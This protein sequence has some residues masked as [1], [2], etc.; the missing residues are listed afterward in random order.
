[1]IWLVN[2]DIHKLNT[3]FLNTYRFRHADD[4]LLM[5]Q[6]EVK[7]YWKYKI[8]L[9]NEITSTERQELKQ[10][11][12]HKF[13]FSYDFFLFERAKKLAVFFGSIEIFKTTTQYRA[14]EWWK[15]RVNLVME[16]SLADQIRSN[17][18]E[19]CTKYQYTHEI[20]WCV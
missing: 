15:I 14:S 18:M 5:Q 20:T 8:T 11:N 17:A 2:N 4:D 13:F 6:M 9:L 3:Q 7:L 19:I 10:M 12:K 16:E 1:M